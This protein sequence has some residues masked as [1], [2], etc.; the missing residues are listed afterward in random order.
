MHLLKSKIFC[1]R[2]NKINFYILRILNNLRR[3]FFSGYFIPKFL[4]SDIYIYSIYFNIFI[5]FYQYVFLTVNYLG[6]NKIRSIRTNL[7]CNIR[8][9]NFK[10]LYINYIF[11]TQSCIGAKACII[12]LLKIRYIRFGYSAVFQNVFYS[13]LD[14]TNGSSLFSALCSATIS[15][16]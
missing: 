14:I 8:S 13:M 6:S 9:F 3:K 15:H 11:R 2:R 7:Y 5:G 10:F 12:L 16:I 4:F 1:Y